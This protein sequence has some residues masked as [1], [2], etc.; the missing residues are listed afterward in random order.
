LLIYPYFFVSD[1]G[2][3]AAVFWEQFMIQGIFGVVPIHLIEL[4]PPAFRTFVVGTSYNLG[5]AF[6]SPIPIIDT[7]IGKTF[8]ILQNGAVTQRFNYSIGMAI[9]LGCAFAYLIIATFLGEEKRGTNGAG[10]SEHEPDEVELGLA[11]IVDRN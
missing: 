3:Y 1:G 4:S 11:V 6:A 8:P 10:D 5:V 2:L 7:E 9:F